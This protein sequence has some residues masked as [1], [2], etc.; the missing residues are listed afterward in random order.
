ME[1][2]NK[3]WLPGIGGGQ[4]LSGRILAGSLLPEP[5]TS[6]KCSITCL[7]LVTNQKFREKK[8]TFGPLVS[9]IA[10]RQTVKIFP[11]ARATTYGPKRKRALFFYKKRADLAL[12]RWA[13]L[14]AISPVALRLNTSEKSEISDIRRFCVAFWELPSSMKLLI[15]DLLNWKNY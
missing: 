12:S 8:L 13:E 3:R 2:P 14:T 6:L 7:V 4:F 10:V 1:V 15:T 11:L 9:S 5:K